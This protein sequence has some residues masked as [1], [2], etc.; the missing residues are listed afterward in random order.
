MPLTLTEL[1]KDKKELSLEFGG[2]SL[3]YE[4]RPNEFTP[5]VEDLLRE[6]KGGLKVLGRL[7]TS[8][9]LLDKPSGK[10]LP[11]TVDGLKAVPS[12]LINAMIDQ[13]AECLSP[14]KQ[15]AGGSFSS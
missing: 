13:M 1:K 3:K 14:K 15:T 11:L 9:D 4:F 12:A 5:E 8:W 7:V 2:G 6:E 10:P